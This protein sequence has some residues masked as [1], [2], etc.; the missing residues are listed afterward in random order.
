MIELEL[1]LRAIGDLRIGEQFVRFRRGRFD[2]SFFIANSMIECTIELKCYD[3]SF[4][5]R[6]ELM[7]MSSVGVAS[8]SGYER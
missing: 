8:E 2:L 6:F 5:F 7:K 3:S 1:N 4:R